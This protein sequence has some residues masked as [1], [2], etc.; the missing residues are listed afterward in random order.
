MQ[1]NWRAGAC[2]A[3]ARPLQS[4]DLHFASS[5]NLSTHFPLL[6]SY[7]LTSYYG[8][9]SANYQ[10]QARD[11]ASFLAPLPFVLVFLGTVACFILVIVKAVTLTRRH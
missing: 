10:Q 4:R 11:R 7:Y 3:L 5:D 1:L 8:I 9:P 2:Q 6:F